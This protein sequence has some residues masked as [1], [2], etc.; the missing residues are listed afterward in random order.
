MK[1]ASVG[2]A[3][4][5]LAAGCRAGAPPP[6]GRPKAAW[7]FPPVEELP[8]QD[9]MPDPFVKPDGT[10]VKSRDE[11]PAQREYLKS[12]LAHYLYGSMPP[13]PEGFRLERVKSKPAFDG[14]AVQELYAITLKRKG[15]DATF[16]FEFIGPRERGRV[17][18][19]VKNC[20]QLFDGA[21]GETARHDMFAARRAVERGYLLCKFQR[22]EVADDRPGNRKG[23]VFPLYPEYDWG[24]I[25][26]WAWA[27]G[28]V[29][30]A[31][32]RLK[33][34]DMKRIVV[35][36]HSRGGKTALC[37]GIYDERVA[38]TA[39]NSS[40]TGGTGSMRWFEKGQREQ[41]LILH[42]KQFPHWWV[43]RHFEF[44]GRE[45]RLPFDAHTAKAL[46]APRALVNAHARQDYWA[47][48]Y[49]TELTARAADKVFDWLG[50]AGQQGIHWRDGGHAQGEED[51]LALL[52]FAD[53]KL[54]GNL[55]GKRPARSFTERAYPDAKLPVKWRAP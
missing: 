37:A 46:V 50:A 1:A 18:V 23:G 55:Q 45:D 16:H 34:A 29:V 22:K 47:N 4:L 27:H 20:S 12:M 33:L 38:V 3:L 26:A 53:W 32:D 43:G 30:D 41:R 31:L 25:A 42:K 7:K 13:R 44:G 9:G 15:R 2:P 5:L 52:D 39:P 14:R 35:T 40:G 48:P 6:S 17:P 24:T 21:T 54:R 19:I 49:G 8:V 10:R 11:W 28:V 36:G 51:W